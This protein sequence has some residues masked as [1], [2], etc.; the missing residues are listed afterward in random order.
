M[1]QKTICRKTLTGIQSTLILLLVF[2]SV[3]ANEIHMAARTGNLTAI[4]S[5][6]ESGVQVDQLDGEDKTALFIAAKFGHSTTVNYLIDQGASLTHSPM[7]IYGSQGTA[8]HAAA[9]KG[10]LST[11]KILLERG[12]NPN[13]SDTGSG[14]PLHAALASSELESAN[15]LRQ[16]GAKPQ[17]A[18][19]I[20][21]LLKQADLNLG[22]QISGTC[23]A[24][25]NISQDNDTDKRPGPTL[26]NIVNRPK[27]SIGGYAYSSQLKKQG[28][29]WSYDDLN[30]MIK[31]PRAFIPGT[32]MS[33]FSGIVDDERRA[34]LIA[35]LNTLSDNPQA[36]P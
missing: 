1:R 20:K 2:Q 30:S 13:Q 24:C 19:S 21:Y 29:N 9:S 23:R 7:G 15:L 3:S 6:I 4:K 25:H 35:F 27:A 31:N 8:L 16:F 11:I 32:N 28:G 26:W 34:A 12:A 17:S 10:H 14:P 36:L 22:K 18:S 33:V 5:L